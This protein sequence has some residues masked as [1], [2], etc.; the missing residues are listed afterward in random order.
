MLGN[1]LLQL[2]L[3]LLNVDT[4][5]VIVLV[6]LSIP[7][8][9]VSLSL[10]ICSLPRQWPGGGSLLHSLMFMLYENTYV[11]LGIWGSGTKLLCKIHPT[12]SPSEYKR[13]SGLAKQVAI[14]D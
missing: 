9:T 7:P 1:S 8:I 4:L 13:K 10:S 6:L 11:T 3:L 14:V 5:L 2:L 12:F